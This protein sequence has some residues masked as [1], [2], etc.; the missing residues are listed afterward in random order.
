MSRLYGWAYE[1]LIFPAVQRLQGRSTIDYLRHLESCMHLTSSELRELQWERIQATLRLSK[2]IPFYCRKYSTC[3]ISIDDIGS[4]SDFSRL[5]LLTKDEVREAGS[6]MVAQGYS[7]SLNKVR[8][9]G[10]TGQPLIYLL[11][12]D[13]I[14]ANLAAAWRSRRR[15]G[16][17][18]RD[19][20]MHVWGHYRFLDPKSNILTQRM[21]YVQD[22]LMNRIWL[23]A[24]DMSD[25][26]LA[27]YVKRIIRFKP[28][29]SIGY[30]SA[31]YRLA[32]YCEEHDVSWPFAMKGI[33][34]TSENCYEFQRKS[35]QEAFNCPTIIEYG[36][37]EVGIVAYECPDGC[38]HVIDENV[39]VEIVPNQDIPKGLGE[40][41][42]TQLRNP[43]TPLIRY[44]TGDMGAIDAVP[45]ACGRSLTV[46]SELE[47]RHI[48]MLVAQDGGP[49]HPLYIIHIF[50]YLEN[51]NEF[52][53][54]QRAQAS[55]DIYIIRK[56]PG[57]PIDTEFLR[58]KMYEQL[59]DHIQVSIQYPKS[60]SRDPSGK[61][62]YIK[63][64]VK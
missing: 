36:A 50:D 47:G 45:C 26:D 59:G 3:G 32:T 27:S 18:L 5:P 11:P 42:I 44:R 13:M 30:A 15:H 35:I 62:R 55:F 54:I 39:Y 12:P 28:V 7:G 23:S 10:A 25:A 40:I 41:V 53:V 58:K 60:L 2:Q 8:T 24:Y 52:Q 64:E 34:L 56:N 22:K 29:W 48:D 6:E 31:L 43:A 20:C 38:L 63:S 61:L 9:G 17:D 21:K 57:K 16:I 37:T 19:P 33:V 14:A 1:N 49:V 4:W 51:V 46:L